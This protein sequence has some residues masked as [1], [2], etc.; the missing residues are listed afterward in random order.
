MNYLCAYRRVPFLLWLPSRDHS[1]H[2]NPSYLHRGKHTFLQ[3]PDRIRQT[4]PN[5]RSP[6]SSFLL[7]AARPLTMTCPETAPLCIPSNALKW[8]KRMWCPHNL[9]GNF[10]ESW[11]NS[12]CQSLQSLRKRQLSE[13]KWGWVGFGVQTLLLRNLVDSAHQPKSGIWSCQVFFASIYWWTVLW[14]DVL[15]SRKYPDFALMRPELPSSR[16][17]RPSRNPWNFARWGHC[18]PLSSSPTRITKVILI[19]ILALGVYF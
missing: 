8:G 19:F 7:L 15:L 10:P 4:L 17:V 1:I 13:G 16:L 6:D 9:A 3:G 2:F 12:S 11:R 5:A 18:F 14:C